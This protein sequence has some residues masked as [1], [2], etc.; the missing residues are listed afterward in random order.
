MIRGC[1][2]KD[3]FNFNEPNLHSPVGCFGSCDDPNFW[4]VPLNS[5]CHTIHHKFDWIVTI[6]WIHLVEMSE[7]LSCY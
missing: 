3:E 2:D 1:G 4:P 7:W 5:I 6:S